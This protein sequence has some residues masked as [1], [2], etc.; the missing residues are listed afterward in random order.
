MEEKEEKTQLYAEYYEDGYLKYKHP[1]DNINAIN[2]DI[3]KTKPD[4]APEFKVILVR[5]HRE[6]LSTRLYNRK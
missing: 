3:E 1:L 4:M 2:T 6:E 5:E